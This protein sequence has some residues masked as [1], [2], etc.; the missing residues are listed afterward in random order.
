M[1]YYFIRGKDTKNNFLLQIPKF[2]Q[3]IIKIY[4]K[5]LKSQKTILKKFKAVFLIPKI[6]KFTLPNPILSPP[7][8]IQKSIYMLRSCIIAFM[9]LTTVVLFESYLQKSA[10]FFALFVSNLYFTLCLYSIFRK[11]CREITSYRLEMLRL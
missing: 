8:N 3:K 9:T 6:L 1:S 11:F 2:I 7:Q 10:E 5:I 4:V